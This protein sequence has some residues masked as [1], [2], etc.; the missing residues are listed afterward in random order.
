MNDLSLGVDVSARR[1]L[2]MVILDFRRRLP[3]SGIRHV[4]PEGFRRC[5]EEVRP[6]VVAIDS[7]PA[8][9]RRGRSRQCERQLM[10]RGIQCYA[11][12]SKRYGDSAFYDWMRTG[13]EAFS[14]AEQ[15]GYPLYLKGRSVRGRA[16]E[17]YPHAIAV[18]LRGVLPPSG[19][20]K[21]KG[22]KRRW[23]LDVLEQHGVDTARLRNLDFVDAALG[24][25]TGLFAL[26]GK[27]CA[28][29]DPDEG[30][31]VL[32]VAQL[33]EEYPRAGW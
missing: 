9:A 31:I 20:S 24:A 16:V 27:F 12:P 32:P 4:S 3:V 28:V 18:V 21:R 2:H 33:R 14:S 1:G 29:G 23:R 8:F 30:M 25:L 6:A 26:E 13:H 15:A 7:P 22:C 11:T 10:G 19:C 17:I 5:L